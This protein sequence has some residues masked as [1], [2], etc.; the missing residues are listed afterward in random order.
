MGLG[1]PLR[2]SENG[3]SSALGC[4]AGTSCS[5]RN[6]HPRTAWLWPPDNGYK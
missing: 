5:E 3:A 2:A 1:G 6:G 4:T